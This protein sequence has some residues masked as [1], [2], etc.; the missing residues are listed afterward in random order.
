M[1]LRKPVLIS[2]FVVLLL[3]M[4]AAL[5]R[6]DEAPAHAPVGGFSA[7][8]PHAVGVQRMAISSEPTLEMSVWCPATHLEDGATPTAYRYAVKMGLPLGTVT[9]A[10]YAG[11]AQRDALPNLAAGPYPL[12]LLSPGFSLGAEAYAWL[13]E[14]LAS[15]RLVVMAP[16][17]QEDMDSNLDALWQ[18]TIKRPRDIQAVLAYVDE[19]VQAG[20]AFDGQINPEHLA[21]VGHSYGGYTA[22]AAAGARIDTAALTSHCAAAQ[23]EEHPAAWLCEKLVSHLDDMARLAGLNETPAGLWPA[24][25]DARVDAVVPLAGDAFMF[26]AEG[27]V[28]V[29]APVLAMGG[30]NDKDAPFAWGTLAAYEHASSPAKALVALEGAEHMLFT[31]PCERLAWYL[32]TFASEFC[33]DTDWDRPYAHDLV[34]H[35]TTAFLLAKLRGE[36][37]AADALA[38]GAAVFDGITYSAQWYETAT[39]GR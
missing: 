17:H 8:G 35:F 11:E 6:R 31:G 22:L 28:E 25:G 7:P 2:I 20:G 18:A 37:D 3:L 9:F 12:V 21:I 15:Y 29:T 19:Q 14:H 36:A 30:T 4:A 5:R 33:K 39:N 13:A 27:L 16:D 26:G 34:K 24:W 10:T 32:R 1:R 23:A 38:P